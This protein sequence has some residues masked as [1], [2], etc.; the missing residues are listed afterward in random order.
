MLLRLSFLPA[1]LVLVLAFLAVPQFIEMYQSFAADL[2]WQ[3]AFLFNWYRV[4]AFVP[5]LFLLAWF[6]WPQRDSRGTAALSVSVLLS[7]ALLA[8]SFW[9][10]Y[11]P[12]FAFGA[13]S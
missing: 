8:F 3:S 5:L 1:I 4:L 6:F 12:V 11:A 9:A 2:P 13:T 10:A 7:C